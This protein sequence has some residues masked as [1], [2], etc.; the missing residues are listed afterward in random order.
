MTVQELIDKLQQVEDK[1]IPVYR[2]D[3]TYWGTFISP[4]GGIKEIPED[5]HCGHHVIF[6]DAPR[7]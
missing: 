1:S 5:Y 6:F 4:L 2:L 3:Y 7:D